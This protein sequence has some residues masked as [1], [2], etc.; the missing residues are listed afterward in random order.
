MN[1]VTPARAKRQKRTTSPAA[2]TED[3]P[4]PP[5][6]HNAPPPAPL[7]PDEVTRYLDFA[8]TA[9]LARRTEVVAA[10]TSSAAAYKTI[11]DDDTLGRVA[12]NVRMANVLMRA[13]KARFK[14]EKD[15]F[16]NGGRAV[17]RWFKAFDAPIEAARVPV[18]TLMNA[19]GDK[20][21]ADRRA[22]AETAQ[23]AADARAAAAA[24]AAADL[25]ARTKPPV[26]HVLNQAFDHAAEAAKQAETAA[27]WANARPAEFTRTVGI[28]GAT[29]SMRQNWKWRVTDEALIPREYLMPNPVAIVAAGKERDA[30]GRPTAVI[31][32][33]EFYAEKSMGVR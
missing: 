19:Y 5:I 12:E 30:A 24:T 7:T 29:T 32:G 11:E 14:T 26:E 9:L 23:R 28:Y 27:E 15:P 25:M 1:Y 16:L 20:V 17:D 10:L 22:L 8:L 4:S 2:T 13:A 31:P 18:Q 3:A 33:V 6:G 21:E